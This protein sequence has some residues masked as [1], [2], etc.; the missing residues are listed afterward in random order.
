M[1]LARPFDT[2]KP[3]E[4]ITLSLLPREQKMTSC[5]TLKRMS[6]GEL[7]FQQKKNHHQAI[8]FGMKDS[9]PSNPLNL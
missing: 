2:N 1:H 5:P 9:D 4:F 6:I 7:I 8:T 3:K